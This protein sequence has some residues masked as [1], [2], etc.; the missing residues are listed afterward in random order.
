MKGEAGRR[1]RRGR[2]QGAG[3]AM[4]LRRGVSRISNRAHLRNTTLYCERGPYI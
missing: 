4:T 1:L 2:G 3:D